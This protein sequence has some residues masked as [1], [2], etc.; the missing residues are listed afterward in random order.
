M[1]KKYSYKF[2]ATTIIMAILG[3]ALAV[4]CVILNISRMAKLFKSDVATSVDYF[5]CGLSIV[6][7]IVAFVVISSFL[8]ASSYKVTDT[9]FIVNWGVVKTKYPVEKITRITFFRISGKLVVFFDDQTSFINVC[10][11]QNEYDDLVD[12]IKS[13]NKNVFYSLDSENKGEK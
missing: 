7:G 1:N 9:H 12:S 10:I 5:S 6:I 3:V 2:T 13:V 4:A 11:E 8:F